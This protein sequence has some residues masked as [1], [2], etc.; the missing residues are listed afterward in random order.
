VADV[1]GDGIADIV[2]IAGGDLDIFLGEGSGTFEYVGSIGTLGSPQDLFALDAHGQEPKSGLPDL[3][4][5]DSS[6]V[7]D[8]ILNVT[9]K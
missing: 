8:V 7:L 2:T 4:A 6:G 5:P 3:V 9:P 1:N